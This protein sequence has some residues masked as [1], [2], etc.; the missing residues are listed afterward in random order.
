M[1]SN[2]QSKSCYLLNVLNK[3]LQILTHIG[4]LLNIDELFK[5]N[6]EGRLRR[7]LTPLLSPRID[8]WFQDHGL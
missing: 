2:N 7:G 6:S 4:E 8:L 1:V 3:G 5:E